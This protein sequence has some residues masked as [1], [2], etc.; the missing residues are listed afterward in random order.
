LVVAL[1]KAVKAEYDSP[2]LGTL[3]EV[4]ESEEDR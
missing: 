2:A 1:R 3:V 4:E